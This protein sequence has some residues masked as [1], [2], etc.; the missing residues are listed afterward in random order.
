[1]YIVQ[2]PKTSFAKGELN[3]T[4]QS[5]K[6]AINW[7]RMCATFYTQCIA[8][9]TVDT[10]NVCVDNTANFNEANKN[11]TNFLGTINCTKNI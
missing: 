10:S 3:S 7:Y 9:D 2:A 5:S 4:L 8:Y 1:M 6:Y 11:K